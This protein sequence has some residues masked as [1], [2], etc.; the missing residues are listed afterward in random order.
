MRDPV[1]GVGPVS[2]PIPFLLENEAAV[3]GLYRKG[4][5]QALCPIARPLTADLACSGLVSLLIR[6]T[7]RRI[8]GSSFDC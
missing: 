2:E 8:E 5:A 4:E 6:R 1:K 3:I 7:I